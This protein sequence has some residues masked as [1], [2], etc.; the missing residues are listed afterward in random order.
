MYADTNI[1]FVNE[2]PA[3]KHHNHEW[4]CVLF[5]DL[6]WLLVITDSVFIQMKISIL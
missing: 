4:L 5:K 1:K 2:N 3:A 6:Y